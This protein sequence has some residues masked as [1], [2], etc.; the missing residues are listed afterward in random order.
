M[1]KWKK[2]LILG[3]IATAVLLVGGFGGYKVYANYQEKQRVQQQT[4]TIANLR[5]KVD[6]LYKD[7]EKEL[8]AEDIT[9]EQL[10]S[11]LAALSGEVE[12]REEKELTSDNAKKLDAV[13]MDFEYATTMFE[14]QSLVS[15]LLDE[16][17]I[18]KEGADVEGA[19]TLAEE[20]KENKEA[21]VAERQ[22]NID[23]AKAQQEVIESAREKLISFFI[24]SENEDVKS[25][26]TR[27][28]YNE[29]KEL[30]ERIK[31]EKTKSGFSNV[32]MTV[33]RYLTE[34]EEEAV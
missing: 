33:D 19:S 2:S 26:V 20:L 27:T 17:E 4:E 8:L 6:K 25:G 1:E 11:I 5:T 15:D 7:S 12:K 9:Q 30:V 3:A 32:L 29:A 31:Q 10:E 23:E 24:G 21:F 18:L 22:P 34:Q 13:I 14:L 16:N 28:D